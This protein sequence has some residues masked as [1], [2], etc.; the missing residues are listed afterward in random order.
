MCVYV[1]A[2]APYVTFGVTESLRHGPSLLLP[3]SEFCCEM[4]ASH[5]ELPCL[6]VYYCKCRFARA[7]ERSLFHSKLLLASF[8]ACYYA[9]EGTRAS[10]G[11]AP[12][13]LHPEGG[14]LGCWRG[15]IVH[16]LITQICLPDS[17]LVLNKTM[18][19][20]KKVFSPPREQEHPS[21]KPKQG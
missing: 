7:E 8:T 1:G 4:C 20:W 19:T 3:F 15:T 16:L 11:P 14:V 6:F 17:L 10:A 5:S 21:S 12:S 18:S 2:R 9:N 13:T